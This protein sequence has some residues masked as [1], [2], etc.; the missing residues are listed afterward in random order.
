MILNLEKQTKI[1][2]GEQMTDIKTRIQ[3]RELKLHDLSLKEHMKRRI[4][5]LA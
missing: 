5:N 2:K 1:Q 3:E 4:P